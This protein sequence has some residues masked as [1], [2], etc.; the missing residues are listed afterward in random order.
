MSA[1]NRGLDR[2]ANDAYDTPDWL[3]DPILAEVVPPSIIGTDYRVLEPACGSGA[4]I[5][6][7]QCIPFMIAN[8]EIDAYDIEPRG[9]GVQ[10]D[11][12]TLTAEKKYDLIITNPPFSLAFEFAKKCLELRKTTVS[13]VAL[14]L[15]L[16][17][18]ASQERAKWM[19]ANTPSVYVTPRRPMF[20]KNKNG[21]MGSD[22]TDYGWFVLG[23]PAPRMHI[24]KT[25]KDKYK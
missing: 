7:I 24:L 15:R 17:W 6:R 25:E 5:K 4:I 8:L 16:N 11:F 20:R 12:L 14:L 1:T 3:I 10:Q 9:Y 2:I 19:R 23:E 22:A 21:K 13:R 18:A